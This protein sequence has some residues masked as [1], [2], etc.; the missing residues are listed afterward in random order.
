MGCASC[1]GELSDYSTVGHQLRAIAVAHSLEGFTKSVLD[2]IAKL[3]VVAVLALVL[4][5]AVSPTTEQ[6]AKAMPEVRGRQPVRFIERR[7]VA[8]HR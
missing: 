6:A 5:G 7:A 8:Q 1:T 4:H 3:V 2:A